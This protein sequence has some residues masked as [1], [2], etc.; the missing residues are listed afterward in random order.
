MS[1]GD[2]K[3]DELAGAQATEQKLR[4]EFRDK[5]SKAV[6]LEL[7]KTQLAD[8]ERSFGF[9]PTYA[10]S[11]PLIYERFRTAVEARVESLPGPL[12]RLAGVKSV[13]VHGARL[14]LGLD[15][16]ETYDIQG[17]LSPRCDLTLVIHRK[18][19]ETTEA[20]V[21]CRLDTAAEVRVYKA[22]GVLQRFAQDFLEGA[23]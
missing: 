17:E 5:H 12:R 2:P 1:D 14:T 4:Q 23:A 18:N 22:G 19:G 7:Y 21:T 13:H 11:V 8:I 3:K 10:F 16:T 20:Q 15:G 6:N 9:G